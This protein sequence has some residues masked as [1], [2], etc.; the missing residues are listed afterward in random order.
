MK[1]IEIRRSS[2]LFKMIAFLS[3]LPVFSLF[4]QTKWLNLDKETGRVNSSYTTFNDICTFCR[5]IVYIL[6][7]IF[8][9]V[10]VGAIMVNYVLIQPLV[11][12]TGGESPIGKLTL[13]YFAFAIVWYL[14][15]RVWQS[16]YERLEDKSVLNPDYEEKTKEPGLILKTF[17]L[18]SEKHH[19]FCKRLEVKD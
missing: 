5:H 19:D 4:I 17:E 13:I 8:L 14:L 9:Y 12:L 11:F 7:T 10:V 6:M 15:V 18:L 3:K 16:I 1:N 2:S